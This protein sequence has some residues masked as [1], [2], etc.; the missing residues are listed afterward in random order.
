MTRLPEPHKSTGCA[1]IYGRVRGGQLTG[2]RK[3]D[4]AALPPLPERIRQLVDA[5]Y[6]AYGGAEHMSL[7]QWRALEEEL[8]RKLEK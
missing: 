6:A 3:C 8:V 7:D 1:R 4:T 2:A 5:A